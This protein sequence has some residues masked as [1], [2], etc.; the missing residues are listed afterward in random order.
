[1]AGSAIVTGGASG[2][3]MAL[4]QHLVERGLHVVVADIDAGAW[5][6]AAGSRR[7]CR[8]PAGELASVSGCC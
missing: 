2:I 4:A 3:G 8:I 5:A 6:A 1:M 7:G